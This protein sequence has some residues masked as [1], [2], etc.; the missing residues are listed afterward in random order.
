MPMSKREKRRTQ[1]A[2]IL[3]IRAFLLWI[4]GRVR[5]EYD[6]SSITIEDKGERFRAFRK[7]VVDAPK[8]PITLPAV[9][10]KV[11]FC[12]KNLSPKANRKLSLIPIPLIVAQ[13]GIRSKT[14]LLGESSGDFMGYYEFDTKK[15]AEAYWN[16][17]P[18]KMMRRRAAPGS[19]TSE[20]CNASPSIVEATSIALFLI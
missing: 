8:K 12:F 5:F 1:N 19:L 3:V 17:L 20:I 18:L 2:V 7:M 15:S 4:S 11:R 9:I 16:S 10:F 6:L 14:W 13:P